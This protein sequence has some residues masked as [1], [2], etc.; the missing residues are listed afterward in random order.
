MDKK[1]LNSIAIIIKDKFA[2]DAFLAI[3][4]YEEGKIIAKL[5]GPKEPND[6]IRINAEYSLIQHM[7]NLRE[8]CINAEQEFN[9]K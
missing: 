5:K 1:Y 8:I 9:N 4:A 6:L 7:K 2:W 3:L